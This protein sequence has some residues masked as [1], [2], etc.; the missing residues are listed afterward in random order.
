MGMAAAVLQGAPLLTEDIDVVHR[1]T[2]EN[3]A[4]L[5]RVLSDLD[6]VYRTD[7]RRLRPTASHLMGPRHQLLQTRRG[8][9]DCLGAI[10]GD[11]AYDDLLPHTIEIEIAE[12]LRCR[13]VTLEHL[14]AIK[15]RA[16]RPKDLA[17]IP[18][19]EATLEELRDQGEQPSGSS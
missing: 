2:P 7:Q 5:L 1:R 16:A 8:D 4:R 19:L 9:L 15:R 18:A 13:A 10:D 14:I 11:R 17:V 6:A 3:V 12:G